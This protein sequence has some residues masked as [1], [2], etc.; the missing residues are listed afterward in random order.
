MKRVVLGLLLSADAWL[1]EQLGRPDLDEARIDR[2]WPSCSRS[3]DAL[4]PPEA[5]SQ[6]AASNRWRYYPL[7]NIFKA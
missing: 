5:V 3:T 7:D 4:S 2:R 6:G 1:L